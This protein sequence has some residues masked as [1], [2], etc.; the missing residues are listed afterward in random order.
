MTK[1][2]FERLPD[3]FLHAYAEE[4]GAWGTN[5]GTCNRAIEEGNIKAIVEGRGHDVLPPNT[6]RMLLEEGYFSDV[7]PD[8]EM[9]PVMRQV[10]LRVEVRRSG[11]TIRN[12]KLAQVAL[13]IAIMPHTEDDERKIMRH[14]E[15]MTK[16][17]VDPRKR[18][19]SPPAAGIPFLPDNWS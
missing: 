4:I 10:T 7:S 3:Y 2:T 19:V 1:V 11:R 17:G 14:C 8:P 13:E 6:H 9:G 15:K 5:I 16:L 18:L 12:G